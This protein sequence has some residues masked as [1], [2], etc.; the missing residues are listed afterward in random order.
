VPAPEPAPPAEEQPGPGRQITFGVPAADVHG[1][2]A[3]EVVTPPAG[4]TT[5]D[6]A[7]SWVRHVSVVAQEFA[8]VLAVLPHGTV[9]KVLQEA[10]PLIEQISRGVL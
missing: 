9:R 4:A 7:R 5:E 10:G 2:P 8:A 6:V 1:G 3:V